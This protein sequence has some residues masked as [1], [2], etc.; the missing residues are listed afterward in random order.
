MRV[1]CGKGAPDYA[2]VFPVKPLFPIRL[3]LPVVPVIFKP[4]LIIVAKHIDAPVLGKK[5]GGISRQRQNFQAVISFFFFKAHKVDRCPDLADR[6]CLVHT[7]RFHHRRLV[8]P[9]LRNVIPVPRDALYGSIYILP[10]AAVFYD[11]SLLVKH[12]LRRR[13]GTV[14]RIVNPLSFSRRQ[15]KRKRRFV[16]TAPGGKGRRLQRGLHIPVKSLVALSGRPVFDNAPA[17]RTVRESRVGHVRVERREFYLIDCMPAAVRK[18]QSFPAFIQS[19]TQIITAFSRLLVDLFPRVPARKK[20]QVRAGRN[21]HLTKTTLFARLLLVRQIPALKRNRRKGRVIKLD[22]IAVFAILI[23]RQ[24]QIRRAH[25][26][27]YNMALRVIII[28]KSGKQDDPQAGNREYADPSVCP[29]RAGMPAAGKQG[30]NKREAVCSHKTGNIQQHVRIIFY[31]KR[32]ITE[33][34]V[35]HAKSPDK[36]QKRKTEGV[37]HKSCRNTL[38]PVPV[39]RIRRQETRYDKQNN[40]RYKLTHAMSP[41]SS[42]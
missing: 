11:D 7:D 1:V 5:V 24:R 6:S 39:A 2:P 41:Q 29:P 38:L 31:R 19:E 8:D 28:K 25:L 42:R 3:V 14:Q 30:Q 27:D 34:R 22:I 15:S 12:R 23:Q 26:V 33:K 4:L 13:L 17:I 32:H 40:T 10:R 36:D 35:Q 9:L 16:K 18:R 21:R 37:R 20:Q